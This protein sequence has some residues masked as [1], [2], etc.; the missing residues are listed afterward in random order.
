MD[1]TNHYANYIRLQAFIIKE[2]T[3]FRE[4]AISFMIVNPDNKSDPR[5]M[6]K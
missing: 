2:F 3:L 4:A 1:D 5:N 6:I